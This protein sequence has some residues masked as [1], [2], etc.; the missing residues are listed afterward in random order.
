MFCHFV[1]ELQFCD[2]VVWTTK[3]LAT[4]RVMPDVELWETLLPTAQ[5]F[6]YKVVLPELVARHYI[7]PPPPVPSAEIPVPS[8][9]SQP[10]DKPRKRAQNTVRKTLATL[11]PGKTP[12]HK[13]VPPAPTSTPPSAY[14]PVPPAELPV[15]LFD[16]QP[17]DKNKKNEHEKT[18]S[19]YHWP[20][21]SQVTPP[22]PKE[23]HVKR[24]CCGAS[25]D[26]LKSLM[27]W[28]LAIIRTVL[29]SG[30]I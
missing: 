17:T 12:K 30:S 14:L 8:A 25:A 24:L 9:D 26:S 4:V 18:Q 1:T 2:F 21:C 27:I 10:T 15:P 5:N 29:C 20:H 28:L 22:S 11:Q 23:G 13:V 6:F 3:S 16:S 19:N 7:Q